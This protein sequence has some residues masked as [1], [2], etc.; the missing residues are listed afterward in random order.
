VSPAPAA[1]RARA[2]VVAPVAPVTPARAARTARVPRATVVDS[3]PV[4]PAASPVDS[5]SPVATPPP[6]AIP[7]RSAPVAS[8]PVDPA[9]SA[10]APL[11]AAGTVCLLTYCQN[12]LGIDPMLFL[13]FLTKQNEFLQRQL[14][15]ESAAK[16]AIMQDI[17]SIKKNVEFL[18]ERAFGR[19][20]IPYPFMG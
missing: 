15:K 10:A 12:V 17:A 6:I 14:E 3:P 8:P 18:C 1:P 4:S 9:S 19:Q 2:T 20:Q 11:P 7:S 16:S 13:N 5:P